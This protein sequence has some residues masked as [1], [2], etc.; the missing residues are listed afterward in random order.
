MSQSQRG[1]VWASRLLWWACCS[2]SC[3]RCTRGTYGIPLQNMT[4]PATL[5]AVLTGLFITCYSLWDKKSL[6]YLAPVT[7]NEF[8]MLGYSLL[9]AGRSCFARE[10]AASLVAEWRERGWT[11]LAAGVMAPLGYVL[12][13]VALTTSR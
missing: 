11:I 3:S 5:M 4:G 7:V 9:H 6:D 2:C 1:V 8:S 12:V 13:L 10:G